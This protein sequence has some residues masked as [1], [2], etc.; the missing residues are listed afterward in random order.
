MIFLKFKECYGHRGNGWPQGPTGSEVAKTD[1]A[2]LAIL[3]AID[4]AVCR[5]I[6]VLPSVMEADFIHR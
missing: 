1:F 3:K 5:A 4:L 2:I 6:C